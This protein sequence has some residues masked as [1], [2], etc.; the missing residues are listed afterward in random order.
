[1]AQVTVIGLGAMGSTLARV[2]LERGHDVTTWNRSAL[3]AAR[4]AMLWRAGAKQVSSPAEAIAAGPLT[5]MCVLDYAAADSILDTPGACQALAGRTLVQLSN[6]GEDEVRRQLARVRTAG[7]RMLSGGIVGYPRH[8]GLTDT[9]ILYAGSAAAFAEHR[10]T[11]AA[12]AGGQRFLGEDPAV[13]NATY[14]ASFAFYYAALTGFLEGAAL[15][16]SRGVTPADF[17]ATMPAMTALLLDHA[18]DAARRIEAGDYAG[19]QATVDV[20]MVGSQRRQRTFLERGQQSLM[21]DGFL[22]YCH[23]AHDAGEGGQDIAAIYKR[24]VAPSVPD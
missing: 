9:V 6:G 23:Q 13:Q 7:G 11:L 24:I 12:L 16:G 20:H 19:D 21:T 5:I 22:T 2:L 17:A 1:M 14:V 3:P 4:A 15:A 8:I 10:N 18:A